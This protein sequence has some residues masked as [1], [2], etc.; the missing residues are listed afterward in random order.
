MRIAKVVL[1]FTILSAPAWA[2][3][4]VQSYE[5]NG[6][7][8]IV[9]FG[10]EVPQLLEPASPLENMDWIS[11]AAGASLV[12]RAGVG[13]NDG[14][15]TFSGTTSATLE[16]SQTQNQKLYSIE[17][18][19]GEIEVQTSE[20]AYVIWE[21]R[22]TDLVIRSSSAVFKVVVSA[23]G[24]ILIVTSQGRVW[25][26]V[27]DQTTMGDPTTALYFVSNENPIEGMSVNPALTSSLITRWKAENRHLEFSRQA[28]SAPWWWQRWQRWQRPVARS[29]ES[30]E[31]SGQKVLALWKSQEAE[32]IRS[33]QNL[34]AEEK[35]QVTP[36][37]LTLRANVYA[38]AR[39]AYVLLQARD[40]WLALPKSLDSPLETSVTVKD[41]LTNSK[42]L[43]DRIFRTISDAQAVILLLAKRSSDVLPRQVT[44]SLVNHEWR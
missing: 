27:A 3:I 30:L 17:L 35:R 4:G 36:S 19:T 24:G 40:L 9:R 14:L 34:L 21:V 26:T 7:V 18:L 29:W 23:R 37:I 25:V 38:W 1:L 43:E 42:N 41:F 10:V 39:A 13:T 12:L 44:G 5:S 22:W 20:L 28:G 11:T 16:F 15:L 2:S 8:K 32:K 6:N 33:P 31:S